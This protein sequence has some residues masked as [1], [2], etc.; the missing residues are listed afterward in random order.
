[1]NIITFAMVLFVSYLGIDGY[2]SIHE[3]GTSKDIQQKPRFIRHFPNSYP[4][5][6]T[7][8]TLGWS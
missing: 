4:M 3:Y 6:I 1:M 7:D 8:R 2:N 5:A